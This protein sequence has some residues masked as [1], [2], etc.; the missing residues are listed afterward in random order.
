MWELDYKESW[1][2]NN[3]YFWTVVFEKTLESPLDGR[4]IKPVNPK[5]NQSWR[6]IGRTDVKAETN[7]L[8]TWCEELTH[9]KR[10]WCWKRSKAGGEGDNRGW[11]G[12]ITDKMDMSL[13]KLRKLLMDSEAWHAPVHG[14]SKIQS[15]LSNW[16]EQLSFECL[17]IFHTGLKTFYNLYSFPILTLQNFYMHFIKGQIKTKT[18]KNISKHIQLT[19]DK[20]ELKL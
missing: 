14:V 8:A 12:W 9:W 18:W 13:S 15:W 4:E 3:W 5:G 20:V 16:T 10:P 19:R 2:P 7:I 17:T 11:D 6:F 1:T